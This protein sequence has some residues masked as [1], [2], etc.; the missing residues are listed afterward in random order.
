MRPSWIRE[1][2]AGG[3]SSASG[4]A[5]MHPGRTTGKGPSTHIQID[6]QPPRLLI[7]HIALPS[8][9]DICA[10]LCEA[11][12]NFF[13]LA[14]SLM[15]PSRMSLFSLYMVQDQHECILP[16]VHFGK[17]RPVDH[18]RSGFRDQPGQHG[19]TS[20]LL[21]IQ[22]ITRAWWQAP[23]ISATWKAWAGES[24]EPG[25][26]PGQAQWLMPVIPAL[27]EAEAGRSQGQEFETS[28]AN[29]AKPPS[30]LKMQNY[31]GVVAHASLWE[32]KAG[33][34]QD[35]E[36][37]TIMANMEKP[38][39]LLKIQKLAGSSDYFQRRITKSRDRDQLSQ[40]GETPSLLKIQKLARQGLALLPRLEC[41]GTISAHCNL[42]P[43][44]KPFSHLNIPKTGFHDVAQAG[45]ELLSSNHL[46]TSA[47]QS[48]G[49][50]GM[51][52]CAQPLN[53]LLLSVS[54]VFR[55]AYGVSLYGPDWS[56][57]VRSQLTVT[58]ASQVQA[59]LTLQSP[60]EVGFQHVGQAGLKLLTSS[61]PPTSASQSA[62][63][64]GLSHCTWPILPFLLVFKVLY[65][66]YMATSTGVAVSQ[67]F[68]AHMRLQ[69][70]G[71][72]ARLQ[73]CIS[74]LRM[75]QREGCFRSQGTSLRL[76]VEDGL[77]QFKQYSRHVTTS[78]ALT[79]TSL[80][81]GVQWHDLGSPQ[82]LPPRFK[83]F[84]CLSFLSSWDYRHEPPHSADFVLLVET[85][86]LHAGVEQ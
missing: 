37:E 20:S 84:S 57:V 17:L 32:G 45:L 40:H 81:A 63:I 56:V 22:K 27:W 75:L 33:R 7:V 70:K 28:L 85:G 23:V 77:Q 21:K 31:P 2:P 10:N 73:A 43:R 49:I 5:A 71:N 60:E 36:I 30:L 58:S 47:S 12:Q 4:F 39:S 52:H 86:F 15:G 48:A 82:P 54:T 24:L 79:Y 42:P 29:M 9:A 11:L 72:F 6:Q 34:S 74:E 53:I 62:G 13:S 38:L 18:L 26:N 65:V 66:F 8:W 61:D 76:A 3:Y 14:C 25:R 1:Y 69:V 35:Q 68:N 83:Q 50:T 67:I 51:S 19:E 44:L 59:I 78:A 41:S 55:Y 16:F 46:P 80:E 64:T